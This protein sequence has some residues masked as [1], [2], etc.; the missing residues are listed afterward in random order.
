MPTMRKSRP[1]EETLKQLQDSPYCY[2]VSEVDGLEDRWSCTLR[3]LTRPVVQLQETYVFI[4]PSN[5]IHD[6]PEEYAA[7][8]FHELRHACDTEES[9]EWWSDYG[10]HY[11]Y[12]AREKEIDEARVRAE[13][14]DFREGM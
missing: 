9:H 7:T 14:R 8:L 13:T 2:M 4:N 1:W 6:D 11:P 12:S 10:S 3:G 5:M